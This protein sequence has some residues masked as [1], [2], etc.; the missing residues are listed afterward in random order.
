MAT[1]VQFAKSI[2]DIGIYPSVLSA[3]ILGCA[4]GNNP[5]ERLICCHAK[6]ILPYGFSQRL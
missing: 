6:T 2:L 1:P 5:R 4:C 3:L